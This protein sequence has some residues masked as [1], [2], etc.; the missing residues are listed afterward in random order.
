[1]IVFGMWKTLATYITLRAEL[2][3]GLSS[4]IIRSLPLPSH[5]FRAWSRILTKELLDLLA[6][7]CFNF[8]YSLVLNLVRRLT[9]AQKLHWNQTSTDTASWQGP[10]SFQEKNESKFT[11]RQIPKAEGKKK[12][13][14]KRI[15]LRGNDAASPHASRISETISNT[16]AGAY[17]FRA[18]ATN[19]RKCPQQNHMCHPK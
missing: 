19:A 12:T 5:H 9:T 2:Q 6:Y 8:M 18:T 14:T 7:M 3:H 4:P 17:M 13:K 15:R 10:V 1:M 16:I 11:V